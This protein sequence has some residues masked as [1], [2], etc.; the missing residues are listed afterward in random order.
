MYLGILY[1]VRD[2]SARVVLSSGD[3][4]GQGALRM[5]SAVGGPIW[6]FSSTGWAAKWQ[7]P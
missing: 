2:G 1:N 3:G 6:W 5:N 7:G 4:A